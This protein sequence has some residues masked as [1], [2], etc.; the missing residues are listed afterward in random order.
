MTE[1]LK[2]CL[3]KV[4]F[5]CS[6]KLLIVSFQT[7]KLKFVTSITTQLSETAKLKT[8]K[9]HLWYAQEPRFFCSCEASHWT[10]WYQQL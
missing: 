6:L 3:K 2:I 9:T 5:K 4:G 10:T 1:T 7:K 8:V